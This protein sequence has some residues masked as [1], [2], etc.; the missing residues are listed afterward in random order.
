MYGSFEP[1]PVDVDVAVALLPR[2]AG[3]P[4]R[5]FTNVPPG[6]A[7][8]SAARRRVEDDDV[9]ALRVPEAV[10]EAAGE[11]AVGEARL[12][13]GPGRAQ[14]SVGSIELEGIRYGLTTHALIASTITIAPTIVTSQSIV[15]RQ[16]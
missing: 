11:H 13:A 5:R 8:V 3:S 14:C 2:V 12:A 10:A 1:L 9:A 16:P 4:I 15:T 6:A 7:A